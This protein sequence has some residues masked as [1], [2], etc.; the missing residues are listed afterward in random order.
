MRIYLSGPIEYSEDNGV[1]WRQHAKTHLSDDSFEVI[2]PCDT[3]LELLLSHGIESVEQYHQ[4][5][6][7]SEEDML[8]FRE[9]TRSFISHDIEEVRKADLLLT[10]V[11]HTASGGTSGEITLAHF[12]GITV[13]AFCTDNVQEVSGWVQSVP[14]ILILGPDALNQALFHLQQPGVTDAFTNR[15]RP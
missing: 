6:Y 3:S 10:K 12:L 1:A 9:A 15:H 8:L 14:D 4:L 11:S 7:G 5:K 2:D 13:L